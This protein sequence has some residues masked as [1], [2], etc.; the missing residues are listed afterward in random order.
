MYIN[1]VGIANR[2]YV[3]LT[4][5]VFRVILYTIMMAIFFPDWIKL[6]VTTME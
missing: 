4:Q 6:M 1:S 5:T 3:H 2:P